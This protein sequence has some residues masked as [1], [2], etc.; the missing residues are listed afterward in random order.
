ML[1]FIWVRCLLK[2]PSRGFQYTKSACYIHVPEPAHEIWVL[3]PNGLTHSSNTHT[4]L[5][6]GT[7]GLFFHEASHT[8]IL[9]LCQ[10]QK[11][12]IDC[13]KS[14]DYS[15]MWKVL[16]SLSYVS[17]I[18]SDRIRQALDKNALLKIN[19]LISCRCEFIA[20]NWY[21]V[22]MM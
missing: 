5:S 2:Y 22:L 12:W 17:Y 1:H 3:I 16:E 6:S 9:C 18:F 20:S 19:L 7:R 21:K 10:K 11:L 14:H 15:M 13:V 4:Q 8:C